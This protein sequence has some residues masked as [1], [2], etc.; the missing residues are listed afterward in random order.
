[1]V[2]VGSFD[3]TLMDAYFAQVQKLVS[4]FI[5]SVLSFVLTFS[6]VVSLFYEA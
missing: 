2:L 1:M 6:L 5:S 3:N 4:I